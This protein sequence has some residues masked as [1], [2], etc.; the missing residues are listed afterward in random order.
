MEKTGFME[1]NKIV[2]INLTVSITKNVNDY[3]H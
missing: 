1:K 3:C 2:E